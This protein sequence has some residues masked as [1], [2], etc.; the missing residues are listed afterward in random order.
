MNRRG[1]SGL[2]LI[3]VL[4]TLG[5]LTLIL[6]SLYGTFFSV[7]RATMAHTRGRMSSTDERA[8]SSTAVPP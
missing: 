4:I 1:E 3:E 7:N 2:T 5:V 8:S 6:L